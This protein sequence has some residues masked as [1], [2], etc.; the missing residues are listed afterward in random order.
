M[1][2]EKMIQYKR[3]E[4]TI[5]ALESKTAK[6]FYNI[7]SLVEMCPEEQVKSEKII[8]K[9]DE[10]EIPYIRYKINNEFT[11]YFR[12]IFILT[13]N[14][15]LNFYRGNGCGIHKITNEKDDILY[16]I[17]EL[18]SEPEG[19]VSIIINSDSDNGLLSVIPKHFDTIKVS[20]KVNL[21]KESQINL[22]YEDI[23]K[24]NNYVDKVLGIDLLEHVEFF[25]S[26]ILCMP[27]PYIRRIEMKL[28]DEGKMLYMNILTRKNR[29]VIGFTI[30]LVD[31]RKYGLGFEIKQE[32]N[33]NMV[34]IP[35]PNE[36]EKLH[37]RLYATDGELIEYSV[38]SF[39][40]NFM[41]DMKVQSVNRRF[42]IN[43]I[44]ENKTKNIEIQTYRTIEDKLNEIKRNSIFTIEEQKR[45][46]EKLEESRTFI[47]FDGSSQEEKEKAKSI[48]RELVGKAERRCIICDPYFSQ[49]DFVNYGIYIKSN[50][51]VLKII[52][53]GA[54]LS[55]KIQDDNKNENCI[56][57]NGY[58]LLHILNQVEEKFPVQCYVLKGNKKSPLHDRFIIIDDTAYLLGSS[59]SEFGSR[60]TTLYKVPDANVL[61]KSAEKW[62]ETEPKIEEWMKNNKEAK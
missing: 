6:R 5:V 17:N 38:G 42:Q 14:E 37:M 33:N 8:T 51:V 60:A 7:Y 32:I 39:I 34:T 10:K 12:R 26:M 3:S 49:E 20:C 11:L 48:I 40:K 13:P 44:G 27:D 19:E 47:Y 35:L 52:T 15:A 28:I 57:N 2:D 22:D 58:A 53:S 59:L 36:P 46:A 54:F 23:R 21:N 30:N 29:S 41:F 25:G 50:N 55:S 31:E 9:K 18:S 4:V 24:I 56:H 1:L 61:I 16:D 43:N 62:M 45:I